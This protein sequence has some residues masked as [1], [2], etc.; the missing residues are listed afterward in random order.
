MKQALG[1]ASAAALLAFCGIVHGLWTNR[2]TAPAEV[3]AAAGRLDRVAL[4]LGDWDGEP[5]PMS[6]RDRLMAGGAGYLLRRYRSRA[7]GA[8]VTVFLVCG[9]PGP[10]SVHTPDVCFAGSGYTRTGGDDNYPVDAGSLPQPASFAVGNFQADDSPSPDRLRVFWS[11]NA[12][13]TWQ[14]PANPR[15]AFARQPVLHKLYL[16]RRLARPDEPLEGD[17]CLDLM[18]V[19]LPELNKQL[20]SGR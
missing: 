20:F 8:S 18:K 10:V 4:A 13:G 5:L 7:S 19:L 17:P 16:I 14:A 9:R 15:A 12:Q 11:W 3:E 1:A 6:D 2:W